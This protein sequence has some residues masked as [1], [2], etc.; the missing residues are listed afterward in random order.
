[1]FSAIA[2]SSVAQDSHTS[3]AL[4]RFATSCYKHS[5]K[6]RIIFTEFVQM[7]HVSSVL[8]QA[9]VAQIGIQLYT[10]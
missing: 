6:D 4:K 2:G 5:S 8:L 1:M 10:P 3:P 9:Q 7:L